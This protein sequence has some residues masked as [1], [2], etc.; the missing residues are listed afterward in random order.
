M[1]DTKKKKSRYGKHPLLRI[2]KTK[3]P[4]E[5]EDLLENIFDNNFEKT[6]LALYILKKAKRGFDA[7][8]W[9]KILLEFLIEYSR[10]YNRALDTVKIKELLRYYEEN[11]EVMNKTRLN[12]EIIKRYNEEIAAPAEE[13]TFD[14]WRAHYSDILRKF[15]RGGLLYKKDWQYKTSKEFRNWLALA[16]EAY[17]NYLLADP[18][19]IEI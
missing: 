14:T 2:D 3:K 16:L 9:V 13:I 19:D 5:L 17:D 11:V 7:E 18:E 10:K 15:R 8:E 12:K 4:A 6:K 1:K